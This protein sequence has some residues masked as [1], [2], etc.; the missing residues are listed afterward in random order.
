M[1]F[2]PLAFMPSLILSA[3]EHHS[4]IPEK[5]PLSESEF[6]SEY[7]HAMKKFKDA[8]R[9]I[10]CRA[11]CESLFDDPNDPSRKKRYDYSAHVLARENS[12]VAIL[13]YAAETPLGGIYSNEVVCATP[14]YA[15]ELEKNEP[16]HPYLLSSVTHIS[17]EHLRTRLRIITGHYKDCYLYAAGSLDGC[18]FEEIIE[19][20]SF[21]VTKIER[22]HPQQEESSELVALDFQVT[23]DPWAISRGHIVFAPDLNWAVLEYQYRCDF[24]ATDYTTYSGRNIYASHQNN[25][26]PVPE[27]C[28]HEVLNYHADMLPITQK[29]SANL[30]DFSLGTVDDSVFRL[31]HYGLPD[32]PLTTPRPATNNL[33]QWFLI[34]NGI[35]L[36]LI[37][38]Y[39]IIQRFRTVKIQENLS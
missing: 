5:T 18:L 39:V 19:K 7:A 11:E 35:L 6:R 8:Y 30:S 3:R 15:F 21:R 27:K 17:T 1:T 38:F 4:E 32:T 26:V 29:Y 33:M 10:E 37:V 2:W 22:V 23:D 13:D 36:A 28:E 25:E 16:S 20:P 14:D 9:N 34:G 31:S 12:I 24:T